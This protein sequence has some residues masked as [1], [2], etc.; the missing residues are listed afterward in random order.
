MR[1]ILQTATD[2][3]NISS[4][5]RIA[6][7]NPEERTFLTSKTGRPDRAAPRQ[8]EVIADMGRTIPVTLAYVEDELE[9]KAI[10]ARIVRLI[11]DD[12]LVIDFS[13]VREWAQEHVASYRRRLERDGG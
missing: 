12:R 13:E 7:L 8:G 2:A 11:V 9:G 5:Q 10:V 1:H 6:Y 4:I 3:L